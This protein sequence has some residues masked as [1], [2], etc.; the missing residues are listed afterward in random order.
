MTSQNQ[1]SKIITQAV[2]NI[3]AKVNFNAKR[4]EGAQVPEIRVKD[5]ER[6]GQNI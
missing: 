1:V 3:Q 4:R 2:Q 6:L 5:G